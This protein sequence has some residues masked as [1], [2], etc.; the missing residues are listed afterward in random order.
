MPFVLSSIAMSLDGKIA[1]EKGKSKWISCDASRA[2]VHKQRSEYDA[3]M[4][5]IGTVLADNPMLTTRIQNQKS[6]ANPIR[7]IIDSKLK[8]PF[9]A[10]VLNEPG[11]TILVC[12]KKANKSKI[13]QLATKGAKILITKSKSGKVSLVDA[14]KSLGKLGITCILM[15][16]GSKLNRDA[17]D[18]KI[19][20]KI[21]IFIA[22]KLLGKKGIDAFHCINLS[23]LRKKL[24]LKNS[25]ICRIGKDLLIEGYLK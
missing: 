12:T 5:G 6:A 14:M 17:L 19:I 8:I 9:S 22:P 3:V 4:V 13:F 21:Q 2:Y 1:D 15:Q 10:K 24:K 18:H 11:E 16:A 25:K 23:Q 20:N 7:I